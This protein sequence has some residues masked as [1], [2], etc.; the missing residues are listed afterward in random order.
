MLL[1]LNKD[2]QNIFADYQ[3][4]HTAKQIACVHRLHQNEIHFTN[5]NYFTA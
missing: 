4:I 1:I 3:F 5:A 2:F